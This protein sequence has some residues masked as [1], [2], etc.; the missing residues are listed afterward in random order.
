MLSLVKLIELQFNMQRILQ[1]IFFKHASVLAQLLLILG[2]YEGVFAQNENQRLINKSTVSDSKK[3]SNL[4]GYQETGN[5]E[6]DAKNYQKAKESFKSKNGLTPKE[7]IPKDNNNYKSASQKSHYKLHL[8]EGSKYKEKAYDN[9][10]SQFTRLENF[11]LVDKR[12]RIQLAN[13]DG[14]IELYS[15]NE[16]MQ[17]YGRRIR[18]QNIKEGQTLLEIELLL[19][20]FGSI[21]EQLK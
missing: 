21:K 10:L 20:E 14:E 15:A 5:K 8:K 18:P 6:V 17:L 4:P 16:L 2:L 3:N 13:N 9:A 11:R 7:P 19:S 12:R 1:I